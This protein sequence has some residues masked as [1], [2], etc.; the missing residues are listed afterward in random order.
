MGKIAETRTKDRK[1]DLGVT[2]IEKGSE[3]FLAFHDGSRE[4][5]SELFSLKKS[6]LFPIFC[7]MWFNY[8]AL[9]R[10]DAYV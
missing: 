3:N 7:S 6:K 9:Q 10:K 2:W 1:S 8:R 5:H 4:M